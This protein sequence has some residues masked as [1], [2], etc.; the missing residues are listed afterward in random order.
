MSVEFGD[1]IVLV[2]QISK[3]MRNVRLAN[4]I[5]LRNDKKKVKTVGARVKR[6]DR[7]IEE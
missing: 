2:Y 6:K 4:N 1:V 5:I 3:T 7:R